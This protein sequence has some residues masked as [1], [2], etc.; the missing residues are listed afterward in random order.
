MILVFL[1]NNIFSRS[2]GISNGHMPVLLIATV[3]FR[4]RA[5][6][7]FRFRHVPLCSFRYRSRWF[8]SR[9][10][11]LLSVRSLLLSDSHV[12]YSSLVAEDT[13]RTNLYL[14][15]LLFALARSRLPTSDLFRALARSDPRT[16][17]GSKS[18]LNPHAGAAWPVTSVSTC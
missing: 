6:L 2:F 11:L 8:M 5:R 18:S 7:G 17:T 15:S 1:V 13:R 12:Y 9:S 3:P 4:S 16:L 10:L 14:L